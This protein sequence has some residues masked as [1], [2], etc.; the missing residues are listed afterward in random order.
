MP[1]DER[2]NDAYSE[3]NASLHGDG[4]Q[5]WLGCALCVGVAVALF[6]VALA[7]WS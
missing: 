1:D 7:F 6:G 5:R 3:E 4:D 2:D